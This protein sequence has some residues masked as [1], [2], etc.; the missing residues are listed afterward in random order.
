MQ[1]KYGIKFLY[2]WLR[3]TVFCCLFS[4][5]TFYWDIVLWNGASCVNNKI[6]KKEKNTA[7]YVLLCIDNL[8]FWYFLLREILIKASKF[9]TVFTYYTRTMGKF[10]IKIW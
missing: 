7:T 6:M 10:I 5:V 2:L 4:F 9:N 1:L 8:G 3:K